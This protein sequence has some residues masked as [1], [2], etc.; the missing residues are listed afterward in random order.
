MSEP[1]ISLETVA[2]LGVVGLLVLFLFL[3]VIIVRG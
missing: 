2:T 1:S 3:V